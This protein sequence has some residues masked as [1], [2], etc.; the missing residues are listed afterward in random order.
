MLSEAGVRLVFVPAGDGI[1]PSL[2]FP[3]LEPFAL[4]AGDVLIAIK[5][6]LTVQIVEAYRQ[7]ASRRAIRRPHPSLQGR[8]FQGSGDGAGFLSVPDQAGWRAVTISTRLLQLAE[9]DTGTT[10]N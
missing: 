3:S 4:K 5:S 8:G 6:S 2:T 10:P 1:Q 9:D 7:F